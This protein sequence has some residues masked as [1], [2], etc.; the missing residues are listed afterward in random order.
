M[1]KRWYIFE[2]AGP[3]KWQRAKETIGPY[4]DSVELFDADGYDTE[5]EAEKALEE[6]FKGSWGTYFIIKGYSKE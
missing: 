3:Y 1:K 5:E 4:Y 6:Y 2:E